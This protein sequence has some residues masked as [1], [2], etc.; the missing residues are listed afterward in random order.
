M[1]VQIYDN[2][3]TCIAYCEKAAIFTMYHR[4]TTWTLGRSFLC[5]SNVFS[6]VSLRFKYPKSYGVCLNES[7]RNKGFSIFRTKSFSCVVYASAISSCADHPPRLLQG[8]FPPCQPRRGIGTAGIDWCITV[9]VK[10][11]YLKILSCHWHHLCEL[12]RK[13]RQHPCQYIYIGEFSSSKGIHDSIGVWV[14]LH[15]FWIPATGFFVSG[16]WI[17]I[18]ILLLVA[19]W[20][21]LHVAVFRTPKPRIMD[22][23]TTFQIPRFS[24]QK[25]PGFQECG[26][27]YTLPSL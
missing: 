13:N 7:I 9:M 2:S 21:N 15:G 18:P 16:T 20:I 27:P 12:S 14:P 26:F 5:F 11:I 19:F 24:K 3:C 6:I 10:G 4:V 1:W 8:I 17:W 25:F 22:F 23:T